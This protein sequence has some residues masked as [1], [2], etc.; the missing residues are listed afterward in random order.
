MGPKITGGRTNE[1]LAVEYLTSQI[2]AIIGGAHTNQDIELDLQVV[3]G[4]F[5]LA[6]EPHGAIFSYANVQN[7]VVKVHSRTTSNRSVLI[8]TH[9]DTVPTSPGNFLSVSC[10]EY[11]K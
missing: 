3:S 7:I 4:S 9:F 6:Y 10:F 8:N 2:R 1:V 11:Q 5:Y